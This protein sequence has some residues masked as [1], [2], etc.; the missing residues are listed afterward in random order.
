[1]KFYIRDFSKYFHQLQSLCVFCEFHFII[2]SFE[3]SWWVGAAGLV[4]DPRALKRA[5]L[6]VKMVSLHQLDIFCPRYRYIMIFEAIKC[7]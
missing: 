1:M 6:A 2:E 5:G 7:P 3:S 4:G